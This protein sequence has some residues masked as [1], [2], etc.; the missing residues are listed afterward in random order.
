MCKSTTARFFS[1][2]HRLDFFMLLFSSTTVF[3]N[4]GNKFSNFC[5][6]RL[7]LKKKKIATNFL[8]KALTVHLFLPFRLRLSPP[9][10]HSAPGKGGL[11]GSTVTSHQ[12]GEEQPEWTLVH[13][14]FTQWTQRYCQKS[15]YRGCWQ[16]SQL[17]WQEHL[18]AVSTIGIFASLNEKI[19]KFHDQ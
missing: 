13:S 4:T 11:R 18:F 12:G 2:L 7:W 15:Q 9:V 5:T 6:F 17:C 19:I 16:C 8:F 3:L 1:S 10:S 14:G